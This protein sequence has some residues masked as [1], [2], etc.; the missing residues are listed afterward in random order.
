MRLLSG[1]I[2]Y[3]LPGRLLSGQKFASILRARL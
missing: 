3:S 2:M 1:E